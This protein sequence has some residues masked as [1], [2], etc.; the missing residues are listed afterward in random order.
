MRKVL[1]KKN[2]IPGG[3]YKVLSDEADHK[4]KRIVFYP[5]KRL[6]LQRR[7]KNAEHCFVIRGA[8]V[9]TLDVTDIIRQPVRPLILPVAPGIVSLPG[10]RE[11]S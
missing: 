7:Q 2:A 8:G 10:R 1:W 4:V 6:S 11:L 9:V 3:N 5:G